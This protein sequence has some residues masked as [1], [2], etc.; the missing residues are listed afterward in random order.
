MSTGAIRHFDRAGG[1]PGGKPVV[2][3]VEEVTGTL[4]VADYLCTM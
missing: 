1:V 2:Y 3:D 4:K